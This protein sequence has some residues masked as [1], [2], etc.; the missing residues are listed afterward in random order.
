MTPSSAWILR[1][2][3]HLQYFV[4]AM[5]R[6]MVSLLVLSFLFSEELTSLAADLSCIWLR[7]GDSSAYFCAPL[8]NNIFP[9]TDVGI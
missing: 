4:L 9:V 6:R 5:A 2:E 8:A 3:Y 7:S 1:H